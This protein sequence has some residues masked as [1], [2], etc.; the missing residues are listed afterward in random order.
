MAILSTLPMSTLKFS[1]SVTSPSK[2]PVQSRCSPILTPLAYF[3]GRYLVIPAYFGDITIAGQHHLPEAGPVILA[4][5]H[6]ARWDSIMLPLA[7]GR[8]ATSRDLR[9]MVTADEVRGIQGWFIRRLGGFPVN[10]RRPTIASLRYGID[11]LIA[12]EM[13]VIYPEGGIRREDRVHPLKPGLGRLAV[14]AE[15]AQAQLNVQVLPV[16]IHYGEAYPSWRCPVQITIGD[17]IA[18]RH[19]LNGDDSPD[20]L[21]AGAKELTA[22]LQTR[23]TTLVNSRQ[24]AA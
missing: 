8:P 16:D 15:A 1:E 2:A 23:L 11:L 14:Q 3:L 18:V 19:Y 21:K 13:L 7:A 20:A 5:T 12:G 6:R 24:N 10:V 9:F 17:P 4:P 22:D